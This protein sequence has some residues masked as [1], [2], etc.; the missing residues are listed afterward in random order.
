MRGIG[1]APF[2]CIAQSA[3]K[4]DRTTMQALIVIAHPHKESFNHAVAARVAE[5]L[6]ASNYTVH[7]H[8]L[9]EQAFNP[10]LSSEEMRRKF[11]LD[12]DI[13]IHYER[14]ESAD[15]LIFIHP[16]W[17]GSPPA[18]LKGWIDRV[19]SPGIAY[20]YEGAEFMAKDKI[21][22]LSG[23]KAG[24]FITSNQEEFDASLKNLHHFWVRQVLQFCGIAEPTCEIF[25]DIRHSTFAQRQAWIDKIDRM[26][27]AIA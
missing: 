25:Y 21:P 10:V 18:I 8:D 12:S 5:R 9:Y 20:D 3:L 2:H 22:L 14:L 16:D 15:I 19:F 26:V 7:V 11:S 4:Q 23:K 1:L 17:W 13:Q 6:E 27:A 24:V